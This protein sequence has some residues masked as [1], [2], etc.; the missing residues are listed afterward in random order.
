[1]KNLLYLKIFWKF[2]NK[3]NLRIKK[4]YLKFYFLFFIFEMMMI[5]QKYSNRIQN[6]SLKKK[7]D[8]F[9]LEYNLKKIFYIFMKIHSF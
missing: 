1:M 2:K 9:F 6:S 4:I 7:R 3:E 8:L 5:F